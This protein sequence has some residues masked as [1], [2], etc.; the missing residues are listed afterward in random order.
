MANSFGVEAEIKFDDQ[1]KNVLRATHV[2]DLLGANP[3]R[4]E[5]ISAIE[6]S[7]QEPIKDDASLIPETI[8]ETINVN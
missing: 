1:D 3:E 4:A 7:T 6:P 2:S 8:P 5:T